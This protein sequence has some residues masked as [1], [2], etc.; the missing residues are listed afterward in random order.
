MPALQKRLE[1]L[2]LAIR[3]NAV[4]IVDGFDFSD[5]MLGS[6]L[7]AYDGNV[8]QRIF[9]EAMKNPMNHESV[10]QSFHKYIKPLLK[11]SL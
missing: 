1:G 11:S 7:G 9:D 5:E 10:N 8:Y 4:G 2:L 6:T 3:P